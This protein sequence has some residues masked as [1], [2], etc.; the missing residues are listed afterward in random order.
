MSVYEAAVNGS[1][2]SVALIKCLRELTDLPLSEIRQRIT[3]GVAVVTWDADDYP[4][5]GD[6]ETHHQRILAEIERLRSTGCDLRFHYRPAADD[7]AESVTFD[8]ILNLMASDIEYDN[9][10]HD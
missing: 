6:R 7:D 9:Q 1:S 2:A 4:L 10:E 3:D 5:S 8:Q